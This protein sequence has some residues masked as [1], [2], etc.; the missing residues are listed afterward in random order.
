[1]L[2][3]IARAR[4]PRSGA[5]RYRRP[6]PSRCPL[7]SVLAS[8]RAYATTRKPIAS[9]HSPDGRGATG[10]ELE[11]VRAEAVCDERRG[12]RVIIDGL[13]QTGKTRTLID[14]VTWLHQRACR[15]LTEGQTDTQRSLVVAK[16]RLECVKCQAVL[17]VSVTKRDPRLSI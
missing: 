13:V 7:R 16:V 3:S 12:T 14:R 17:K 4:V 11:G 6:H 5:L 10:S 8:A 1:M 2:T 15:A 9:A